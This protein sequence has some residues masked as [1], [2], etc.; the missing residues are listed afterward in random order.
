MRA[1][2]NRHTER[3]HLQQTVE[4]AV[5]SWRWRSKVMRVWK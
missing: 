2:E 5:T 3:S 1:G 4:H